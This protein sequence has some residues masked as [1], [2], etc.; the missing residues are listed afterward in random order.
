MNRHAIATLCCTFLLSACT[1]VQVQPLASAPEQ[2]CIKN[3]P[4]VQVSDFVSVMQ[5]GFQRYGFNTQ[6]VDNPSLSDCPYVVT[7]TARRTWDIVPYVSLAEIHI[8]NE[9]RRE[10]ANAHYHLRGKG[11][12]SLMKW[13][14]TQAKISPVMDQLLSKSSVLVTPIQPAQPTPTSSTGLSKEQQVE[15]LRQ[16]KLSYEQYQARYKA[17]MNAP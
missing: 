12:F 1:A 13:Q 16:E 8:F 6:V 10:V 11:G 14:G 15:A 2:L 5:S 17:I 7:Y 4:K 9:Q 3:N